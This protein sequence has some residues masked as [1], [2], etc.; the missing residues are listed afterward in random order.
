MGVYTMS[1][2]R[3]GR[4]RGHGRKVDKPYL[5]SL[6]A[7]FGSVTAGVAEIVVLPQ[8]ENVRSTRETL[9]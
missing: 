1:G 7:Y 8:S 3:S 6:A 2:T 4:E 9:S 5:Y